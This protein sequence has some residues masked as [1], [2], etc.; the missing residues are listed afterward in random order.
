[1]AKVL[2]DYLNEAKYEFEDYVPSKD[3]IKF[4]NFIKLV[5]GGEEANKTP[6]V[7]F[8]VLDNVFSMK[9]RHA[10]VCHR[11]F[12]KTTLMSE[13]MFMYIAVFGSIPNFGEI[14][15]A[16]Y[17]ADSAEG[18]AKNLRKNIE[19][20]YNQSDFMQEY[21]PYIR[22]TDNRLEFR[23][24]SGK[25]FIVKMYGAKTNIRGTKEMGIRPQLVVMDD[26]LSDQDAKSK[27]E[28]ENVKNNVHNAIAKALDPRKSKTIYVGTPFNKNDPLVEVVES[29]TWDVSV[30]PLCEKYP[31]S[32]ENF[33]GSWEDRF[34]YEYVEDEYNSAK[35]VGRI[36]SF[37][38]ELMLRVISEDD[39]IV[40]ENDI[41]LY[42]R[43]KFLK[44]RSKYLFYITTDF[45]TSEKA[46]SDYSVLSVWAVDSNK[47]YFLVDTVIERQLMDK[48]I[49]DLFM[50]VRKYK[51]Q[52]VGIEITGQQGGFISWVRERMVEEGTYF[53]IAT[54]PGKTTLGIRPTMD[55][56]KRFMDVVP[57]FKSKKIW[58]P[59]QFKDNN[60]YKEVF[61]ELN[62]VSIDGFKSKHD[63]FLDTISMLMLMEIIAPSNDVE[64]KYD[65]D[66]DE[67]I[68]I[69]EYEVEDSSSTYDFE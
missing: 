18:G 14:S 43:P 69:D 5:N 12:A 66:K 62:N 34:P 36:H 60:Y 39:M 41:L 46:S 23:N 63:D 20:R 50:L 33:K 24:K 65:E 67:F 6:V 68:P 51:P 55:K 26:L 47:N 3:A 58:L 37:N 17:V 4:V 27:T 44:N 15:L 11:G 32:R 45:A 35:A 48:N 19:F 30:Y 42:D 9:K 64:Y 53:N 22:F 7:H 16:L 59:K 61:D 10:I 8:K 29:G 2:E 52:S 40:T 57:L 31:I 49:K 54:E 28:L 38:Q 56:F 21:V 25:T 13:Y 1:M